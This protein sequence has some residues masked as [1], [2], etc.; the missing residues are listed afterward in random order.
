VN[1]KGISAFIVCAVLLLFTGT[2][3]QKKDLP[4][5]HKKW[6]N[7]EVVYIITS[8]EREVFLKLETDR[9]RDLFIQAFWSHRDPTPGDNENEFRKEH[10]RRINYVNHF[11][12]RTTPKPGWRTDRGRIYIILGEPTDI[13]RF[14]GGTM[15][16]SSVIW[17]YQGKSQ[18]G[19]PPGFNLVFFQEGGVG[20]YK[21]YSPLRHG[22]Q[23]LMTSYY[24][25][26]MDYVGAYN[27]LREFSPDLAEVSLTLIPGERS[28]GL[29]RPTMSSDILMQNVE[30]TPAKLVEERYAKKFLE[31]KD[32]VEVEYSSNYIGNDSLV[33]IIK[34]PSGTYFV[35]YAIEPERLSV[36][37]FQ[38]KYYTTL[39]LNGTV[40]DMAGKSIFQFE[41]NV[42]LEF[43]QEQ[44]R[45]VSHK[46]LSIRDMFPLIPGNF[47]MSVLLKNEASKEFTSLE[48]D[49]IIPEDDAAFQM[50]SLIMGYNMKENVPAQNRLRPF[51]AGKY[52]VYIQVNRVFLRQD[53][54]VTIFQ[55]HAL[56]QE[57]KENGEIKYQFIK[58]GTDFRAFSKRI[59]EYS[60]IP[61]LMQKFSLQDFPPA[62][63]RIQVSLFK[64][65]KEL[66]FESEEFDVTH[67]ENLVRP[68]IYAKLLPEINNP[69]HL[70]WIGSQLFNS[71]K[72]SEAKEKLEK[73]YMKKPDSIDYAL[74][75]ARVYLVINEYDKIESLL[76]PFL[77][78]SEPPKYETFIIMGE[79]YQNLGKWAK[80]ID[81]FN[82]AI[83][84]FGLNISLLNAIGDS[85]F[86]LK[87]WDE[88]LTTWEKSLELNPDQP[89]LRKRVDALKEKK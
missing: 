31:Y 22:P 37:S 39:K 83:T 52:Q 13:Q 1:K 9:E 21:L 88:A 11:Y 61:N 5:A 86:Q 32:I 36:N 20:E 45:Q 24:G 79:A 87:R 56:S 41:K 50:T 44:M 47:K 54:L 71:G 27:Q 28:L 17:F 48:R 66:L 25:D 68:W 18:L 14:E 62:H 12:G 76:L 16:Y 29:G 46:P 69:I 89:Q 49:L 78:E 10:Y 7:E 30:I 23:A 82:K 60:D 51:Q 77:A 8:L 58:D 35:H 81:L 67:S 26:P 70:F 73:A 84:H 72:I 42:S 53:D 3:A 57:L 19:L 38:D 40:N 34:D 55:L 85:Y 65:G 6:L 74:N 15:I 4:E 63:Y 80:A 59:S 33:K 43:D 64:D 75:L 2:L